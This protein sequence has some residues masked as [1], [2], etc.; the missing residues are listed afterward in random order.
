ML[1]NI[2]FLRML[3]AMLVVLYH[4]SAHVR[5][6][7]IEQGALFDVLEAVGFAGVDI[8][9]VISGFIMAYTS[10]AA[11]GPRD[12]WAFLR[13]RVAR[14]Y[15]GYW[16]F[17]LLALAVFSWVDPQFLDKAK[18]PQS[19]ILW[20]AWPL[21]IAVSW[22]LI[23]E[24]FFYVLFTL[25]I[26]ITDSRRSLLLCSLFVLM[27]VFA[28]YS[29]FIRHAYDPSHLT[30]MTAAENYML[31]PYLLEFLGG[32]LLA[33]W[34]RGEPDRQTPAK[35]G[36][37]SVCLLAS[38][39]AVFLL[40][41]WINNRF[42]DGDIEQG[43]T[44]FYRV[45]VFGVPSLLILAGAVRL[46]QNGRRAPLRFSLLAGGASYAIYL[47]HGLILASMQ[48][49]GFNEYVGSLGGWITQ[50]FYLA[51]AAVILG[52]SVLHFR[53]IE[54]PLHRIFKGWLRLI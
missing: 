7:G 46:D 34:L 22:T 25:I 48:K 47:S 27:L 3:A 9:F 39:C 41:G 38:G 31:S 19:A 45:L 8:F 43:Y 50:A 14:I 1:I 10:F 20:P 32:T 35:N 49:L 36:R 21:L 15:S 24:M 40:G 51:L 54:R 17:F 42:F 13:R 30:M 28:L 52:Y 44:V 29:Q 11:S 16:P 23:F 6:S 18:L 26:S 4:T 2:Q 5:A 53:L 37:W 12:G 33:G